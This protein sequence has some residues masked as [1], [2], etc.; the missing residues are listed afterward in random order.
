MLFLKVVEA[1][2]SPGSYLL[3]IKTLEDGLKRLKES[4]RFLELKNDAL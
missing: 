4:I 2:I 3:I 1:I